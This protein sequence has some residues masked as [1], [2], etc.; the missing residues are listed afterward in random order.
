MKI[1]VF[2]HIIT[3]R[4]REARLKVAPRLPE[5]E[6]V[7]PALFDLDARFRAVD[8]AGERYVQI[9]EHNTRRVFGV[10]GHF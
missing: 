8:L 1:D 2:N 9:F 6:R 3:P 4:Y 7:M 10:G 5:Q